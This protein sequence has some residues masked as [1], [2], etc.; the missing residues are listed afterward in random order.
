VPVW[1]QRA[2][3]SGTIMDVEHLVNMV[4]ATLQHGAGISI[5]SLTV[6]PRFAG[7]LYSGAEGEL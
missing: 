2:Y 5:P 3:I 7:G 1:V 6:T 4:H